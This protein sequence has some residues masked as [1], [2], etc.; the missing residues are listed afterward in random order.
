MVSLFTLNQ[1]YI[2]LEQL[3]IEPLVLGE[4]KF[5]VQQ[6]V[7]FY[8]YEFYEMNSQEKLL[9]RGSIG[10]QFSKIEVKTTLLD[11]PLVLALD[12]PLSVPPKAHCSFNLTRPLAFEIHV[13]NDHES[14]KLLSSPIKTMRMTSYGQVINPMLCYYWCS[15]FDVNSA[16][17]NDALVPLVVYNQT[18]HAVELKKIIL[19]KSFLKL[20][21]A[22]TQFITNQVQV[23]ITSKS[24]AYIEYTND[25][26]HTL[27]PYNLIFDPKHEGEL[28]FLKIL[29]LGKKGTGIEYGF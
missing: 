4:R 29:R 25:P 11:R 28:P 26:P 10:K 2:T 22:Q 18:K 23:F 19:Y 24:E 1:E 27:G 8:P 16:E 7:S 9:H 3:I 21:R 14:F 17:G 12:Q 13:L 5:E 6:G 15:H 20:F